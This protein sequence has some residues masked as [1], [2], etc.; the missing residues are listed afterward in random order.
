MLGQANISPLDAD[1]L[2]FALIN[3]GEGMIGADNKH[4]L[5]DY[6]SGYVGML[7]FSDASFIAQ[8]VYD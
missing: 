8:D 1:W 5:E 7:M 2:V 6:L 3:C 4:A